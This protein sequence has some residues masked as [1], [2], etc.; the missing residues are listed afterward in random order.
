MPDLYQY[1]IATG[2]WAN[3]APAAM[4]DTPIP[5]SF[6]GFAAANGRLFVHAGHRK[7]GI[8]PNFKPIIFVSAV[9]NHN[10]IDIDLFL[11]LSDIARCAQIKIT[12]DVA[13]EV[14]GAETYTLLEHN[15]P[16]PSVVDLE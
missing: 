11:S 6:C 2:S 3:L 16:S 14:K 12:I 10:W 7:I 13:R 15:W 8:V 5:R 1:T 4:G 9:Q